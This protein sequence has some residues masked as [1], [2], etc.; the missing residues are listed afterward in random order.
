L[1]CLTHTQE[2]HPQAIPSILNFL[3]KLYKQQQE[4]KEE[5]NVQQPKHEHKQE[6]KQEQQKK[7][8]TESNVIQS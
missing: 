5:E 6:E 1:Q 7:R 3:D 4:V 8:E 2:V